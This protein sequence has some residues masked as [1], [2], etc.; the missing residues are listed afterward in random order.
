MESNI[1][2]MI[3][4]VRLPVLRWLT[5]TLL[6]SWFGSAQAVGFGA[7]RIQSSLGQ[8]LKATIPLIGSDTAELTSTCIKT[9][10]QTAD[11]AVLGS[12]IV[13]IS[14]S[15]RG[16]AVLLSTRQAINEPAILVDV[17]ASCGAVVHRNFSILLD[18]IGM[19]PITA[20]TS[21]STP[22][23]SAPVIS[24]RERR[25]A[26]R[27]TNRVGADDPLAAELT[28]QQSNLTT[29]RGSAGSRSVVPSA[30]KPAAAIKPVAPRKSVLK[31]SNEGFTD[32]E[33][34]SMGHLKLSSS[35]TDTVQPVDATQRDDLLAARIRFAQVLRGDDPGR[36]ADAEIVADVKQIAALRS[37]L[38]GVNRQRAADRATIDE[39]NK[40][41]A[42]LKW[43]MLL[44]ALLLACLAIAG[45]LAWRLR[46]ARQQVASAWDVALASPANADAVVHANAADAAMLV[47]LV[48]PSINKTVSTEF[49]HH[50]APVKAQ[51]H[52]SAPAPA[53]A[54]MNEPFLPQSDRTERLGTRADNVR[55]MPIPMLPAATP[56]VVSAI[57]P[58]AASIADQRDALQFYSSKVEHLKVEEISDVMQ[59]AEFWMS[60]NDPQRAIEILEPF[61]GIEL[62][63]SPIPWLYLLDL[64]RG[65]DQRLKYTA[66][67]DKASR[68]FNA[69]IP[70]WD[71]DG[72]LSDGRTLEDFPHVVE[73]IC[74]LW[75]TN[76]IF[77]YLESLIFDKRE[78]I[79]EGFDLFVYQEIMLLLTM[80]RSDGRNLSPAAVGGANKQQLTLDS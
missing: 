58:S 24:R 57:V 36:I 71:E 35:M 59:E 66:L 7:I 68:V 73:R 64:Y 60:L 28:A 1:K 34:A 65:T 78:G 19:L 33:L 39:L 41:T 47:P 6:S 56:A 38:A 44:G 52:V 76:D 32:A 48:E 3:R 26:A 62:P 12:A 16:D 45:W 25:L 10:L 2:T 74:A 4:S 18:P 42:P 37:Q 46:S 49:G 61:A 80:V 21:I 11:G 63:D 5:L 75:E 70:L 72:D 51:A 9:A 27:G 77:P 53:P 69:R 54:T 13:A 40:T 22:P 8:P 23:E 55:P 30:S 43:L 79:R 20:D 31:L 15:P 17:T 67:H 50:P 14:R 29:P